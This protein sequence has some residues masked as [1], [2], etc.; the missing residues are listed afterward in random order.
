[1]TKNANA[2]T[3]QL[4]VQSNGRRYSEPND[5]PQSWQL[6]PGH[7]ETAKIPLEIIAPRAGLS[8][9]NRYYKQYPGI[10]YRVPV[11]VL[12]GAWPFKYELTAAPSGMT[13]GS[14]YGSTDYGVI[15]WSNPVTSGSPFSITVKVTDQQG[16]TATVSYTLTV[17]TSGFLFLDSVNGNNAN[18]GTL[19]SP[20]ATIDGWYKGA[21]YDATYQDYFIYYRAGS[22]STATD[23][24]EGG[25]VYRMPMMDVKPK[26]HIAYPGE[27]V[28]QNAAS[29]EWSFYSNS[30]GN[31]WFSGMSF[32]SPSFNGGDRNVLIETSQPDH[33]FFENNFAAPTVAGVNGQNPAL[34]MLSNGASVSSYI[35]FV[36]NVIY[37][38]NNHDVVLGYSTNKFVFEGNT[39]SGNDTGHGFYAKVKNSNWSVRANV[40]LSSNAAELVQVDGYDTSNNIEV[41]W[42]NY[43]STGN[44]WLWGLTAVTA[45]GNIWS[46]RNT[47]QIAQH[48]L[49]NV[50]ISSLSFANDVCKFTNGSAN[51][52]GIVSSGTIT[53]GSYSGEECVGTG[54]YVDTSGALIGSYRT[55][56][57]GTRGWEVA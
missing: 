9:T 37:G 44:G 30:T 56:Y 31:V 10:A 50:T 6:L 53:S 33:M 23:A 11:L 46:Y 22:Y 32:A 7:Y 24:T 18:A 27:T 42:N 45:L 57:L 2:K 4:P 29:G 52:H 54:E 28:N 40:G 38:T 19:A 17:T 47:W 20:K 12:G 41:C 1:M 49:S 5:V 21:K 14:T 35:G 26:V 55:S 13:I 48:T 25:P 15:N 3:W 43:K 51:S 39:I 36:R 34:V 8:T 16:N